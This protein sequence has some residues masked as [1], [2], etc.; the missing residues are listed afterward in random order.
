M[1][2]LAAEQGNLP[3]LYVLGKLSLE[4]QERFE[5]HFLEC[6]ECMNQIEVSASF[7]KGLGTVVAE[8]VAKT[9]ALIKIG[10]AA[11]FRRSVLRHPGLALLVLAAVVLPMA[12]MWGLIHRGNIASGYSEIA[13]LQEN[14][15]AEHRNLEDAQ[16]KLQESQ[17]QWEKERKEL[18]GK[19]A[20]VQ[21]GDSPSSALRGASQAQV[22]TLETTRG[23]DSDAISIAISPAS[24]AVVLFL[25]F[26][27]DPDIVTY[28]ASL[29]S[30]TRQVVWKQ[31]KLKLN[32]REGI[33]LGLSPTLFKNGS[34]EMVLDGAT[35]D[36]RFQPVK[37]FPIRV[38]AK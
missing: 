32:S 14:L 7:R 17:V 22:F 12:V 24:P 25:T 31:D 1:D 37:R 6:P 19:I 29:I 35:A 33:I 36:G 5:E 9:Q 30:K 26:E 8:E 2:H 21:S 10:L 23:G 13:A 34:Y 16:K 4:E 20:Q 38:I 27:P 15:A 3:D 28:R 18:E 11:R